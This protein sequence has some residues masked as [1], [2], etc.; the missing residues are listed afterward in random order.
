MKDARRKSSALQH[1]ARLRRL[2]SRAVFQDALV[3]A[4]VPPSRL[5]GVDWSR[6]LRLGT[7]QLNELQQERRNDL[8]L[9]LRTQAGAGWHSLY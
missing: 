6:T 5:E 8:F 3:G 9:R 1:D 7:V 2:F 4:A